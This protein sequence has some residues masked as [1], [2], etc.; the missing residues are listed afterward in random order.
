MRLVTSITVRTAIEKGILFIA[1]GWSPG[2]ALIQSAIL[3]NHSSFIR[4]AQQLFLQPLEQAFGPDVRTYFL[5]ENHLD[6]NLG[7]QFPYNINILAFLHYDKE[8][9]YD[10]IREFGWQP[11]Q[12]TDPNS[13]NCLLNPFPNQVHQHKHGYHPYAMEIAELVREGVRSCAEALR[14]LSEE[15]N[16]KIIERVKEKLGL[17]SFH[18]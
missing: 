16:Q 4:K 7:F 6:N 10:R 3:K 5:D 2:Q 8:D 17:V 1:Y 9:V 18:S 15:P 12:D 13:N 11:P 14:R